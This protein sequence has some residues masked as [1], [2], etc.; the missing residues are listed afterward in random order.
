MITGH[1]LKLAT[2]Q[3]RVLKR[4]AVYADADEEPYVRHAAKVDVEMLRREVTAVMAAAAEDEALIELLD[5][6]LER[7]EKSPH[8]SRQR[9]LMAQKLEEAQDRLYRALGYKETAQSS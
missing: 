3:L 2:L 5:G 4:S 8:Q 6:M 1:Y 7:I 9:T